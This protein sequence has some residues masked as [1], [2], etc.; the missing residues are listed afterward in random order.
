MAMPST[1]SIS[2]QGVT[3]PQIRQ[4]TKDRWSLGYRRQRKTGGCLVSEVF[5]NPWQEIYSL[6]SS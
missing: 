1:H 5:G 6:E 2:F 3:D 4:A